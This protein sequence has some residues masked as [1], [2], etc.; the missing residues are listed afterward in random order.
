MNLKIVFHRIFFLSHSAIL[1]HLQ[2]LNLMAYFGY[3]S[4]RTLKTMRATQPRRS[5]IRYTNVEPRFLTMFMLWNP[6]YSKKE[7]MA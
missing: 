1:M 2:K 3:F 5:A 4:D 6:F 7:L